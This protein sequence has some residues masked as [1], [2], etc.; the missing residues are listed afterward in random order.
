MR[1][2]SV[3][4]GLTCSR[5]SIFTVIL[6][7]LFTAETSVLPAEELNG[8]QGLGG[9]KINQFEND[10]REF[11]NTENGL[12]DNDVSS[13]AVTNDGSV[14]AGTKK[15][16]AVYREGKFH[17]VENVT[18]A[19]TQ[20]ASSGDTVYFTDGQKVYSLEGD[21]PKHLFTLNNNAIHSMEYDKKLGLLIGTGLG[22]YTWNSSVLSSG[23]ASETLFDSNI[24]FDIAVSRS[25]EIALGTE[26]GLI[27]V[28]PKRKAEMIYPSDDHYSWALKDVRGVSYDSQDR[29]W[30][31][32]PQ[33][34]GVRDEKGWTL[35]TGDEGLP[36]NEMTALDISDD[37]EVWFGTKIGAIRKEK[38]RWRYRQGKRWLPGDEIRDL[39][40]GKSGETWFATADGVGVI[41]KK[42]FTLSEKARYFEDEIDR[43]HRRTPYEY[44][45][46]VT[47]K[48]PADKSEWTQHDSD[49]DGL[50]TSMYGAA[51]CF[52]YAATK[53]PKAKERANKAMK[54][55]GFLSEVTQGG[56]HP[57]PYGFPARTILPIDGRNPNDH[58]NREHD[59]KKRE[60]HDP[61]WKILVP[62]WPV[63]ADGKWYWKTD[64]SSDELD[65]HFFFYGIYYDLVAETEEEKE[66]IRKVT[67]R[68]ADHLI[69]HGFNLVDHDG[70]PTRWGIFSPDNLNKGLEYAPGL[71]GLNS[72]SVLSYLKVAYHV[73]GDQKYQDAYMGLIK[74]HQYDTNTHYPKWQIGPGTG[75]QSDDE[76]AFM[77]YY[78]LFN[79]ETDP[80]L[81]KHFLYGFLPYWKLE[82]PELCPLFNYIFAS[83]FEGIDRYGITTPESC[84]EEALTTLVDFPV[85]RINWGYKNGHRNDLE[86]LWVAFPRF[87]NWKHKRGYK[88]NR[89]VIPI[90]ERFVNHWNNENWRLDENG[91]PRDLSCGSSF[92]LPYYMGLYHGFIIDESVTSK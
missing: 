21:Q 17:P 70:T 63:S 77:C 3:L 92:L 29:L 13:L 44:V 38:D 57:A 33:G 76:M 88:S 81:R 50:W 42:N 91:N 47:L 4:T 52:A 8:N 41:R 46:E 45:L 37:G 14:Y 79:Y 26:K 2:H 71:R 40:V 34:A 65:G 66:Y 89:K 61:L 74:E 73:T 32:S 59:M 6:A 67:S 31:A 35:Y 54:A 69:E 30:F 12:P 16:L 22:F 10:E 56:E 15:G 49:N 86:E 23:S 62:R 58:D 51:E 53:D 72:I 11:F 84:L 27:L 9:I 55:I 28:N 85:D 36:Y 24:I 48:N 75:N 90:D 43:Y 25:G 20:V 39:E 87:A 1:T 7:L 83:C 18:D 64:T 60:E 82:E 78:S 68:V 5:F 80:E 19:I